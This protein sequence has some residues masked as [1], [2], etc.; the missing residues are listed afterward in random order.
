MATYDVIEQQAGYVVRKQEPG[1]RPQ[2]LEYMYG[3]HAFW[4]SDY[5][6][7]RKYSKRTARKH[8]R[9]FAAHDAAIAAAV[10]T[11]LHLSD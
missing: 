5:L 10:K 3:G 8:A 1:R 2:Y 7:A 6:Y 9:V 4:V 11:L